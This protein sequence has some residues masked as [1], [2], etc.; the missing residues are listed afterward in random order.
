MDEQSVQPARLENFPISWFAT[1]MGLSGF[2]IAWHRAETILALPFTI[3]HIILVFSLVIFLLLGVMYLLKLVRYPRQVVGEI[4]HPIKLNFFPTISIGLILSSIALLHHQ[5][6]VSRWLW[7]I[8]AVLQLLLTLYVLSVWIHHT[9]FEIQHINP[10]WFIPIV[11]NIL[12]P[13]AGVK[14]ASPEIAWFYFSIGLLFW[15]LLLTIIF[16]RV[17]FHQPLPGKLTPT[18]FILIAPP[19]VGFISWV[20]LTDSL[21]AF[22]R[23]LYYAALFL[24]L[25]LAT[26]L[27]RFVR[28]KFFLSWWAYSFPLAAI[29][30]ATLVMYQR[31]GL[32]FFAVLGQVLLAI[33]T[34][35]ILILLWK[36]VAG[37]W[38]KEICIEEG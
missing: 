21:D 1:V 10:A 9:R 32:A 26:Q 11:G 33:L 35:V 4:E 34:L 23:I 30:I 17:I 20:L 18:L 13:I 8:G 2:S 36:T 6:D 28:L 38:R 3:S 14:F 25:M 22:G 5:P 7:G 16:Y 15:L 12:V 37:I 24:T 31:T 27:D 19:A 29:T